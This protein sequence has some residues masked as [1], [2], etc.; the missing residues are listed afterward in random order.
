MITHLELF[1]LKEWQEGHL[2]HLT[3]I[4]DL[5]I[6]INKGS[7]LHLKQILRGMIRT[8]KLRLPKRTRTLRQIP[9]HPAQHPFVAGPVQ[10][11]A[12]AVSAS[13]RTPRAIRA[14]GTAWALAMPET[15]PPRRAQAD[16][17]GQTVPAHLPSGVVV[18]GIPRNLRR[19]GTLFVLHALARSALAPHLGV[20]TFRARC[21]R[22]G[23]PFPALPRS[24][25]KATSS[26]WAAS[27]AS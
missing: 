24:E 10:G 11:R 5:Q 12:P 2:R 18:A 17:P 20:R 1:N 6:A 13:G 27:A 8:R 23:G 21:T 4:N 19:T 14:C 9:Y 26:R 22:S 7:V 15:P 3:A 16:R 25:R